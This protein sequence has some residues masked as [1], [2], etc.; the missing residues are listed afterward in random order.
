MRTVCCR[1]ETQTCKGWLE[2]IF[3][4]PVLSWAID[5]FAKL[6]HLLLFVSFLPLAVL[7]GEVVLGLLVV[8][9]HLGCFS[10]FLLFSGCKS[11]IY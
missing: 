4:G 1:I 2:R 9:V 3:T 7:A 11:I 10:E 6:Y 5:G 8:W